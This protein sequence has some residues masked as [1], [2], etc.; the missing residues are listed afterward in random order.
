MYNSMNEIKSCILFFKLGRQ[1][2]VTT[3]GRFAFSF[4]PFFKYI[5]KIIFD[6]VL[7]DSQR[8]RICW[9]CYVMCLEVIYTNDKSGLT[10][11]RIPTKCHQPQNTLFLICAWNLQTFKIKLQKIVPLHCH[12]LKRL[13]H[14]WNLWR[15]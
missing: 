15:G 12:C 6:F 3:L 1:F 11:E 4:R 8:S 9:F 14:V 7:S 13:K 2:N 10:N 5:C